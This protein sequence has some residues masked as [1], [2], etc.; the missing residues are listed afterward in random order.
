MCVCVCVYVSVYGGDRDGFISRDWFAQL[1]GLANPKFAS[2]ARKLETQGRVDVAAE[3]QGSLEAE[4]PL[5]WENL[6]L[7]LKAF[8]R[9]NEAHPHYG[10]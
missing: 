2:Q 1:W 5:P 9:L 3:V 10:E 4:F 8:D 7:L 6:S